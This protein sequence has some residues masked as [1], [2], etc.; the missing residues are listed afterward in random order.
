MSLRYARCNNLR[1]QNPKRNDLSRQS[2][3]VVSSTHFSVLGQ[4]QVLL[5]VAKYKYKYSKVL[6]SIK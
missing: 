3:R 5:D 2:Y 4:V 6:A 1:S